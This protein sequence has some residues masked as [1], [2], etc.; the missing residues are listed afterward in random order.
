MRVSISLALALVISLLA[1]VATAQPAGFTKLEIG[2]GI[3]SFDLPGVDGKNHTLDDF[4][5]ADAIMVVFTCNHCPTA[6]AYEARLNKIYEDYNSRGVAVIAISPNDP[7]AV[8]LDELGYSDLG[9]TLEDMK[10]RAI[11]ANFKFPYLYDGETQKTSLAFGVLA[12]PHVFIFDRERMLR[13]KGRIDDS[14][15]K[16]VTSHDARNALDAILAGKKVEVPVTRVFGCSTKWSTKRAAAEKSIK[17]WDSESVEISLI[18]KEGLADLVSNKTDKYRLINVWA[19]WCAP[20]VDELPEFVTINRMFRNRDFEMITVSADEPDSKDN[21]LEFL[22]KNNVAAINVL[23]NSDKRDDLFD[24]IDPKWEGGVPYTVLI[25]PGGEVVYRQHDSIDVHALKRKIADCVGRTYAKREAKKESA[26]QAKKDEANSNEKIAAGENFKT[27]NLVAWCIVP[28]DAES[29]GPAERAKMVRRLGLKRVAY[30]WRKKHI[31]EFEQEILQYKANDIEYF[32]FWNWHDSMEALIKKHEIKPQIWNMPRLQNEL[33]D[34]SDA[35][36]V[37]AIAEQL[38]PVAEKAK[39]LGLKFGIYNHG[40][41]AGEP[42][43]LIAVCEYMRRE[44][45]AQNVGIVYNFHHGHADVEGFEEA[46]KL[47]KPYLLCLNL[48]GMADP[49]SVDEK[50]HANKIVAIGSGIHERKMIQIIVDSGYDGPI[51]VLGHRKEMDAEKSVGE[52][53]DGLKKI[54]ETK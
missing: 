41:W 6:Q 50:T 26:K 37:Q 34:K 7:L 13:Y 5:D 47:L 19:P 22:Q 48:N 51:G 39:S 44:H 24:T 14:E 4:A 46:F 43:N 33:K 35:E 9:D 8:R 18:G 17:K 12:T 15:V 49:K 40:G 36:K 20:C 29:R 32:A 53:V 10:V 21:S 1:S 38:L 16:T 23:F 30:D 27:E 2:A 54:V 42:K 31:P 52:N 25:A 3:P 45:D 11:D 28:F